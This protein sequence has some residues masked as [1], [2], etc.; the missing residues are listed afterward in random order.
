MATRLDEEPVLFQ[1]YSRPDVHGF[2]GKDPKTFEYAEVIAPS[3][4]VEFWQAARATS[5]APGYFSVAKNSAGSF[6]DGGL[7]YNNPVELVGPLSQ[8]M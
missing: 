4:K 1:S 6:A 2:D 7:M 8:E 3:E 5:A